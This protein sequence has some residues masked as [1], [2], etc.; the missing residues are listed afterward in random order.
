MI[1]V[2]ALTEPRPPQDCAGAWDR[3][4]AALAEVEAIDETYEL[5]RDAIVDGLAHDR[6]VVWFRTAG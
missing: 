2:V 6:R 4:V 5:A 1:R 3:D